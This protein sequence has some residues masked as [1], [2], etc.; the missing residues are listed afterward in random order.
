MDNQEKIVIN[1][2]EAIMMVRNRL[3]QIDVPAGLSRTI[4]VPIAECADILSK[5][6][7]KWAEIDAAK[8]A[9][10]AKDGLFPE[11]ESASSDDEIKIEPVGVL[12]AVPA[13]E[14]EKNVG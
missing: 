13:E 14:D 3:V 11:D 10:K 12:K 8:R 7:D 1:D 2:D 9:E 6:L 4:G 5:V